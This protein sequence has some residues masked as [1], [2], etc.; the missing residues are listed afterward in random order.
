MKQLLPS[1]VKVGTLHIG[2]STKLELSIGPGCPNVR[3]DPAPELLDTPE[4][5]A[6][7]QLQNY[8]TKKSLGQISK[9]L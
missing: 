6:M 5:E 8:E 4:L 2:S 9:K 1:P 7:L 3:F